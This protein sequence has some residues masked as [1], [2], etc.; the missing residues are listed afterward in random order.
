LDLHAP[1][2]GNSTRLADHTIEL[3]KLEAGQQKW[4]LVV[5]GREIACGGRFGFEGGG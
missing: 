1:S 4:F 5:S 3:V 2:I